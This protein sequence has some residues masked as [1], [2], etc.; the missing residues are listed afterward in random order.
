M[1]SRITV[2]MKGNAITPFQDKGEKDE[3]DNIDDKDEKDEKDDKD[4]T[5]DKERKD[6][7]NG[8]RLRTI[9]DFLELPDHLKERSIHFI[10]RKWGKLPAWL[11]NVTGKNLDLWYVK[12]AQEESKKKLEEWGPWKYFTLFLEGKDAQFNTKFE[13]P[14]GKGLKDPLGE[15]LLPAIWEDVSEESSG[16]VFIVKRGGKWGAI[17]A[18]GSEVFPPAVD[19]DVL[20]PSLFD[21]ERELYKVYNEGFKIVNTEGKTIYEKDVDRRGAAG[22]PFDMVYVY[23]S[24][25]LLTRDFKTIAVFDG[26]QTGSKDGINYAWGVR[27]NNTTLYDGRGNAIKEIKGASKIEGAGKGIL[28]V[29]AVLDENG[30]ALSKPLWGIF[31]VDGEEALKRTYTGFQHDWES[32]IFILREKDGKFHLGS[33]KDGAV[34]LFASININTKTVDVSPVGG[35][36]KQYYYTLGVGEPGVDEDFDDSGLLYADFLFGPEKKLACFGE[37][38]FLWLDPFTFAEEKRGKLLDGEEDRILEI[39]GG[40]IDELWK[41]INGF[42]KQGQWEMVNRLVEMIWKSFKEKEDWDAVRR[43][44]FFINKEHPEGLSEKWD[45]YRAQIGYGLYMQK[46]YEDAIKFYDE[47][48][49]YNSA[50]DRDNDYNVCALCYEN[51]NNFNKA[52]GCYFK[53]LKIKPDAPVILA[54]KGW[55]L[56]KMERYEE[57]IATFTLSLQSKESSGA[58]DGRGDAYFKQGMKKEALADYKKAAAKGSKNRTSRIQSLG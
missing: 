52:L 40:S 26:L 18:D 50:S 54:N 37:A 31:Y 47:A 14:K 15:D 10:E 6:G 30:K 12:Y 23:N 34:T 33:E 27:E 45:Y 11:E 20:R 9:D 17:R 13:G 22:N 38:G 7:T 25:T 56:L 58:Y 21:E 43:L 28:A 4:S 55:L 1:V 36:K 41:F 2:A 42:K 29:N 53:A 16:G 24:H 3:K 48:F 39:F 46:N 35:T 49:A 32:G 19:Q 5:D 44:L 51:L 8:K 57:A